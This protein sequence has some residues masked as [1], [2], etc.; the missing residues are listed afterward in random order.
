MRGPLNA[1]VA[2]INA[3]AKEHPDRLS[4]AFK[5]VLPVT[6]EDVLA[7]INLILHFTFVANPQLIDA[8]ARRWDAGSNA[9]AVAPSRSASGHALLL[10]N[11]HLPWGDLFTW[12]E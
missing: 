6:S 8:Q 3:Y 5:V 2:G 12:Y 4:G 1:F 11:P 7:H 9:W 10:A